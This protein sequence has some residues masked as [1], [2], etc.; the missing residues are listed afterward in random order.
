VIGRRDALV[1]VF[2][3][4]ISQASHRFEAPPPS[5]QTQRHQPKKT[6]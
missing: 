6:L 2:G 3:T 1:G 4:V 5:T